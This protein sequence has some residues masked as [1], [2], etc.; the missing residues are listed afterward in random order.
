[1]WATLEKARS[2]LGQKCIDRNKP[3]MI[4]IIRQI[5]SSDP[6]FHHALMLDGV[7]KSTKELL[8]IFISG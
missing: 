3:V 1:M 4:W 6:K 8:A 2:I 5:P 7:G